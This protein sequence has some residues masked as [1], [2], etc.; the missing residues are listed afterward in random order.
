MFNNKIHLATHDIKRMGDSHTRGG[1]CLGENIYSYTYILFSN[2][3]LPRTK[4]IKT[5]TDINIQR[6]YK[7]NRD[8][9]N[10]SREI[11]LKEAF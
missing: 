4:R 1:F 11:G 3:H 8:F 7:K 6:I 2:K 5:S 9:D 10:D